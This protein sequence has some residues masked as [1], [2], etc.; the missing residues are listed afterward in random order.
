PIF[1]VRAGCAE[2]GTPTPTRIAQFRNAAARDRRLEIMS[3]TALEEIAGWEARR[4]LRSIPA[5]AAAKR[6]L[7]SHDRHT[8][9]STHKRAWWC[10]Q[11]VCDARRRAA[12]DR[13]AYSVRVLE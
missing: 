1:S 7:V 10:R 12:R 4:I 8:D 6:T 9:A 13:V 11:A 3:V 5:P 2:A